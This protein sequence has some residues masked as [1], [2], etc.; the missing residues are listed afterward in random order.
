MAVV[1]IAGV[2]AILIK[3]DRAF[4]D[5]QGFETCS[6]DPLAYKLV[7][8]KQGYLYPKLSNIAPRHILLLTPGTADM[9]IEKLAYVR[10]RRPLFPFEPDTA[11]NPKEA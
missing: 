1:R 6:I 4:I 2:D 11:F 3:H 10:R 7:V 5:P 9:R 8:V